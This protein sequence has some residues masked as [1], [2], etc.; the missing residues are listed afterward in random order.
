MIVGI[1]GATGVIGSLLCK[2]LQQNKIMYSCFT[3]D[4]RSKHDLQKWLTLN[5]VTQIF[6]LAAIVPTTIV[7]ADPVKAFDV[8]VAGTIN[9]LSQLKSSFEHRKIWF[10][11]A[12]TSHVY[13]SSN[14]PLKEESPIEPISI[15]GKT[16]YIAEMILNQCLNL[17][18]NYSLC[19]GRIFSFFHESQARPFLFP[20][21][22]KRLRAEDLT[23]PFFL[24]GADSERDFL[25]A[26]QVVDILIKLSQKQATGTI[27]IGSGKTTKIRSFVQSLTKTQLNIQTDSE[28]TYLVADVSKLKQV[29]E[30]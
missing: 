27:N 17:E 13:K 19:I 25:N 20:T 26:E 8:N 6:H 10:F 4:I 30:S 14:E 24:Y 21:I 1:T 5:P 3:G 22:L 23:K 9:L 18:T 12:S 7:Q 2:K 29:I 11:Y 28:R 16:K 15:Y